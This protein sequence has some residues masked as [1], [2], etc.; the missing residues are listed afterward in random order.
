MLAD[1]F[2]QAKQGAGLAITGKS[3]NHKN[4]NTTAIYACLDQDPVRASVNAANSAMLMAGSDTNALF[5]M[6][7]ATGGIVAASAANR[8]TAKREV[9]GSKSEVLGSKSEVLGSKSE[10]LR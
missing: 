6:Y 8:Y 4:H 5:G 1:T 9:L 7:V 2:L 3:L 10:V